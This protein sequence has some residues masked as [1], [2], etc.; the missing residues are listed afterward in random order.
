VSFGRELFG[1]DDVTCSYSVDSVFTEGILMKFIAQLALLGI[2]AYFL[3][4]AIGWG[5][6]L[7]GL[8]IL[9]LASLAK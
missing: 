3:I 2:S 7:F 5:W 4:S 8:L 1:Y 6:L 9:G